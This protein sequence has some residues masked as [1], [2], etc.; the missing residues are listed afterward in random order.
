MIDLG[1]L[2]GFL[3]SRALDLN[4]IGE[5]VGYAD[6]PPLIGGGS[7]A[8]VWRNSTM[9]ELNS[10]LAPGFESHD[11]RQAYGI[12]NSGQIAADIYANGIPPS[13]AAL[14]TPV[15][16]NPGDTNCDWD[17]NITDL[18][19]VI[20]AWGPYVPPPPGPLGPHPAGPGTPDLNDDGVVN[21]ADLLTVIQFWGS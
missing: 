3:Q 16:P 9:I 6:N 15:P 4:D 19:N 10:V 12:N 20:A 11:I 1:T 18:L 2:P 17:A 21:I 8:F 7:R 13:R 5:I 14:L